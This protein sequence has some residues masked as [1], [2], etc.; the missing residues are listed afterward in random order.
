M[1]TKFQHTYSHKLHSQFSR[2]YLISLLSTVKVY[3]TVQIH[4]TQICPILSVK[5]AAAHGLAS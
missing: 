3:N 5:A 2:G 1:S 4:Y